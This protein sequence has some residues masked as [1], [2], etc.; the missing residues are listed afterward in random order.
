[1]VTYYYNP[2][3]PSKNPVNR[4]SNVTPNPSALANP[5]EN[6]MC[7]EEGEVGLEK[8]AFLS[9]SDSPLET[10]HELNMIYSEMV[11]IFYDN[12]YDRILIDYYNGIIENEELLRKA[13]AY[14]EE[15]LKVTEIMAEISDLAL[16][17]LKTDSLIDLT[18]IR[19]WY[20]EIYTL[21]A[22]YSLAETYYQLG[23]FEEGFHTLALIPKKYNLT[24]DEVVEHNNYVSLYTFKNKIR[25]SG[26]TIAQLND[27]EIKQMLYFAEASTGLSSSMARGILC[28]FYDICIEDEMIRGLDDKM[29]RGLED[30]KMIDPR[31][32]VSSVSSAFQ[33]QALEN[34]TLVPNPTTGELQITN[35]ELHITSIEVFDVYGRNIPLPTRPLVSSYTT[36]IDISHLAQGLY[37]VKITTEAGEVVKKVIKQ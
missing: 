13:M 6:T 14:H 28:F 5:C 22:K 2:L 18:Q 16:F 34:I 8:G 10:Y 32:S 20:D 37:F 33:N 19:D 9:S 26:R 1:M 29:I 15:I 4:T 24:E 35:Y 12:G 36:K 23:K 3:I 21:S 17:K 27:A 25:E 7:L 11:R 31:K 30:N